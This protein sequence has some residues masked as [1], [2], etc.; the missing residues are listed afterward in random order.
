MHVVYTK[1]TRDFEE[2]KHYRNPEYFAR[3]EPRAE[4]V[5]IEGE[6]PAIAAAYKKAGVEVDAQSSSA[7]SAPILNGSSHHESSYEIGGSTVQLGDLVEA[8]FNESG[9]AP[10]EWNDL[11]EADRD[12]LIQTALEEAQNQAGADQ[13]GDSDQGDA[14]GA[15]DQQPESHADGTSSE[16]H[17][18]DE[19]VAE[20]EAR[21][22]KKPHPSMKTENIRKKL[23]EAQ[24]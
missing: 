16:S 12:T 23:D 1:R 22:G 6:F 10:D 17:E 11:A 14:G 7:P 18:R 21:F 3:I 13:S 24:S 15:E 9:M 4:K 2:G 19:L 20:H 5:T 8:A